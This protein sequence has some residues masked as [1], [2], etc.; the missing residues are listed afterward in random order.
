MKILVTKLI[1]V[2]GLASFL[3]SYAPNLN[4]QEL[5]P[6]QSMGY[7]IKD[8]KQGKEGVIQL[9]NSSSPWK[10]QRKVKFIKKKVWEKGDKIKKKDREEIKVKNADGYMAGGRVFEKVK[11]TPKEGLMKSMSGNKSKLTNASTALS[12]MTK[13][14]HFLEMVLDGKI[15]VYRFYNYPPDVAASVGS[16]QIA[17]TDA[18][19]EDL[20]TNYQILV[21]K[22]KKGKAKNVK[23]ADLSK[24][25]K[26]CPEVYE[27]YKANEFSLKSKGLKKLIKTVVP[28]NT[29]EEQVV[30]LMSAYNDC[31]K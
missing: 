6:N 12:S 13:N 31:K 30:E 23:S 24:L 9:A 1:A 21:K 2:I 27:K 26:D 3:L 29:V 22:G 25:L 10:N 17:D 18:M 14:S 15:K 7:V 5:N 28:G 20:R 16:D 8:G 11:Y 19:F 4:A